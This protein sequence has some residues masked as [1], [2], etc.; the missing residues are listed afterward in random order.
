MYIKKNSRIIALVLFVFYDLGEN[1]YQLGEINEYY[2]IKF[3][4]KYSNP[5]KTRS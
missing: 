3:A 1:L 4:K 5:L 2:Y